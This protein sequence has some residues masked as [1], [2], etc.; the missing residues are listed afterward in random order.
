MGERGKRAPEEGGKC[1][2]TTLKCMGKCRDRMEEN[3]NSKESEK[4]ERR[5]EMRG[6]NEVPN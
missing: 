6:E 1:E 3:G 2:E 5:R 4:R